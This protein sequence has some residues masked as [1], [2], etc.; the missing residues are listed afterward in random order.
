MVNPPKKP[1]KQTD[2]PI[3]HT[4]KREV[5]KGVV[6]PNGEIGVVVHLPPEMFQKIRQIAIEEGTSWGEQCRIFLEWGL[7]ES[8]DETPGPF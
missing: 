3:R 4:R 2:N 5:A 8:D 7:E 6:R 1:S